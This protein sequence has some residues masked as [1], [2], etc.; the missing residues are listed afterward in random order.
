MV[1]NADFL[2]FVQLPEIV[3]LFNDIADLHLI[4][5]PCRLLA[6]TRHKR[7]GGSPRLQL[8]YITDLFYTE[9]CLFC[10]LPDGRGFHIWVFEAPA[11][12]NPERGNKSKGKSKVDITQA[13]F[14]FSP[15]CQ[16]LLTFTSAIKSA[17]WISGIIYSKRSAI[18]RLSG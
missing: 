10:D 12:T 17:S 18:L 8:K 7:N 13:F 1:F 15:G 16:L 14:K 4:E 2:P 3:D 9:A 5:V 6:V 11:G